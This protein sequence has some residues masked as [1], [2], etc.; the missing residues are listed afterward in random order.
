MHSKSLLKALQS[1]TI[2]VSLELQNTIES[3]PHYETIL[4]Q[5]QY[6]LH[7]ELMFQQRS[8]SM[9]MQEYQSTIALILAHQLILRH[10]PILFQLAMQSPILHIHHHSIKTE[11]HVEEYFLYQLPSFLHSHRI[12]LPGNLWNSDLD[13]NSLVFY[14]RSTRLLCKNQEILQEFRVILHKVSFDHRLES[15]YWMD[16]NVFCGILS[17][18]HES[19]VQSLVFFHLYQIVALDIHHFLYNTTHFAILY[20]LHPFQN[21][22]LPSFPNTQHLLVH[23]HLSYN[24][25]LLQNHFPTTKD[26]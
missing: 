22:L 23:V 2:H 4:R 19:I 16:H 5:F 7:L 14:S 26:Q 24:T 25:L 18:H 1:V 10:F 9:V 11:H 8:D 13:S 20:H 6:A 15:K 3:T 21:I 17:L 12:Q